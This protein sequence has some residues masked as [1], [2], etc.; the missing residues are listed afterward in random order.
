MRPQTAK[1]LNR[2]AWT[3]CAQQAFVSSDRAEVIMIAD[4]QTINLLYL[5][6]CIGYT[7]S[8]KKDLR[9]KTNNKSTGEAQSANYLKS[10][11]DNTTQCQ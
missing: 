8:K 4:Q 6:A 2:H 7:R 5:D 1:Q 3:A 10:R 11:T 9:L